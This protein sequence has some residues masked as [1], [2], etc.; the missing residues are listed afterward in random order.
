MLPLTDLWTWKSGRSRYENNQTQAGKV[1][2][3]NH[4]GSGEDPMKPE[5]I[6]CADGNARF[7]EMAIDAGFTYGA[8]PLRTTYFP[9]NFADIDPNAIPPKDAYIAALV[10]HRPRIATV[11]DWTA[12]DQ[13]PEVLEWAEEAA[14]YVET[15]IIIPKVIGGAAALP[16]VIG[17][18]TVRLGYSVPT[19][20]GGTDVPI[21]EFGALPVHLLGGSPHKQFEL[22]KYLNVVSTDG[23]MA[24]KMAVRFCAF[25]D[26]KRNTERGYWPSIPDSD[27]KKWGNGTN[28]ANAP[29]E[30]FRRSCK[31]IME[32]W[33]R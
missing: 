17:G 12:W 24:H 32:I 3:T 31:S 10:K 13:L 27:G 30:A 15:V 16:E 5:L 2:P 19:A 20:H 7:A 8:Q 9:I 25:Y 18:A 6:Y 29:Y 26:P 4:R 33:R 23:N 28:V 11:V 1:G 22:S 21:W 14:A